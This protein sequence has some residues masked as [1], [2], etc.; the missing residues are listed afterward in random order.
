VRRQYPENSEKLTSII[1]DDFDKMDEKLQL[2]EHD[3]AFVCVGT[4]IKQAGKQ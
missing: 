1:I 4:T 2:D 3:A